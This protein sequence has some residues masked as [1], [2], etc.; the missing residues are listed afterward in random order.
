[1]FELK[2]SALALCGTQT[3]VMGTFE[4]QNFLQFTVPRNQGLIL[5]AV[6]STS[7]AIM[8]ASMSGLV[9]AH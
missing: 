8:G 5:G 6:Y 9:Q 2:V 4:L 1:M 3:S 7:I